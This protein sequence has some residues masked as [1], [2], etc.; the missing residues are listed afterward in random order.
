[1]FWIVLLF[2]IVCLIG[3]IYIHDVRQTQ[4]TILRNFP[5]IGHVRYFA[6]TWGEYMRQYV[7]STASNA[8]GSTVR[9]RACPI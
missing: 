7:P 6:E 1:M 5:V 2:I 3:G 8:R 9:P 4:H